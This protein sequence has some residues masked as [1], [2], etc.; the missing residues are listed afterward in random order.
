MFVNVPWADTNTVTSVNGKTGEVKEEINTLI[1]A[2]IE[3]IEIPSPIPENSVLA[4]GARGDMI[5]KTR[6]GYGGTAVSIVASDGSTAVDSNQAFKNALANNRVVIVPGGTYL[7]TEDL[8]IRPHCELRLDPDVLLVF[9]LP[10]D[11]SAEGCIRMTWAS[12]LIGNQGA[13]QV[14]Y[15]FSKKVVY[16]HGYDD[17]WT[18]LGENAAG[19]NSTIQAW[20]PPWQHHSPMLR[21]TITIKD[22]YIYKT[23]YYGLCRSYRPDNDALGDGKYARGI[24]FDMYTDSEEDYHI[25]WGTNIEN[26]R[27]AGPFYTGIHLENKN[28]GWNHDLRLDAIMEHCQI[29]L[30]LNNFHCGYI[31]ATIQP[32]VEILNSNSDKGT[33][34]V[35]H[36]IKMT[37]CNSLDLSNSRVWDWNTNKMTSDPI[38]NIADYPTRCAYA[39]FGTCTN[40]IL[41]GN[42]ISSWNRSPFLYCEDM[43]SAGNS[44]SLNTT[45]IKQNLFKRTIDGTPG[46]YD[47]ATNTLSTLRKKEEKIAP[48]E[49]TF[50][51]A[52]KPTGEA[53][54][55]PANVPITEGY[56]KMNLDTSSP[57]ILYKQHVDYAKGV[58]CTVGPIPVPPLGED[59]ATYYI[60]GLD[61]DYV[62]T[63]DGNSGTCHPQLAGWGPELLP[64]E[65]NRWD[66]GSTIDRTAVCRINLYHKVNGP[67]LED[68]GSLCEGLVNY[69]YDRT[70][71]IFKITIQRNN[72]YKN[73]NYIAF[74][75]KYYS[76][77]DLNSL[78]VADFYET[79]AKPLP[80]RLESRTYATNLLL[81]SPNGT[82]YTITVDDSGQLI[83][84]EYT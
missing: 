25:Y 18:N 9:N 19:G 83:A 36:G 37:D 15:A 67:V 31:Q 66:M 2:K 61:F 28:L 64:I 59:S 34:F 21:S 32:G 72:A 26:L 60:V 47:G 57:Y 10:T 79:G 45:S 38:V 41:D 12:S 29:G 54:Y 22:L 84:T 65:G 35:E 71:K 56:Y 33:L 75:G 24:A 58:A 52:A 55:I 80:Q 30:D 42:P 27:I 77:Y 17:D 63:W 68:S 62:E 74:S 23:D 3:N 44:T 6:Q 14:P 81:T 11:S 78:I 1:D 53:Q 39:M 8:V 76:G 73:V 49:T 20:I 4:Y 46:F 40:N 70:N 51:L 50:C 13:I 82:H 16:A 43:D 7:L 48:L 69:T 5:V